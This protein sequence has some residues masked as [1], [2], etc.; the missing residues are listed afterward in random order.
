[1]FDLSE[2]TFVKRIVVGSRNPENLLGEVELEHAMALLNRCLREVPRGR[3]IGTEKTFAVLNIHE[4]QMVLQS[5]IY[6]VAFQ[7]KPHWMES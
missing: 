1:M 4:H 2:I 7:R 6:H 3:I 5:V